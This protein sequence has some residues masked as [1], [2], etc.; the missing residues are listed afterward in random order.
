MKEKIHITLGFDLAIG[1]VLEFSES[2][3][4]FSPEVE[5]ELKILGIPSL[6]F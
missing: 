2:Y 5:T 6:G 3:F 4:G 1:K